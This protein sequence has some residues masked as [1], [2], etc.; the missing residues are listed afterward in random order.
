MRLS[1]N[2]FDGV[3]LADDI[4]GAAVVLYGLSLVSFAGILPLTKGFQIF[5]LDLTL[6]I[7][8]TNTLDFAE[9]G[10]ILPASSRRIL[11]TTGWLKKEI[12]ERVKKLVNFR[13]KSQ[14]RGGGGG[15]PYFLCFL[16]TI[17]C[18]KNIQKCYETYDII[19]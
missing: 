1:E 16:V 7:A 6:S 2:I 10:L 11:I 17:F 18:A 5:R 14:I 12:R 13:T 15:G 3:S 9:N 8:Q 4:R 19:I